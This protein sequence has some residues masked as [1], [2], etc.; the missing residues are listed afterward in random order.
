[1][2]SSH[3]PLALRY[4]QL[5]FSA[6]KNTGDFN[7]AADTIQIM[8]VS[9]G[10]EFPVVALPGVGRMPAAGESEKDA[11]RVFFVAA[12]RATQRLVVAVNGGSFLERNCSSNKQC[13]EIKT[14]NLVSGNHFLP[15]NLTSTIY[16]RK[17]CWR[18]FL[19][20]RELVCYTMQMEN[21]ILFAKRR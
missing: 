12:T 15:L 6:R 4:R 8:K 20:C 7:P 10:L 19:K 9:K 17:Q 16:R 3:A 11:V 1:M 2:S 14:G 5:S 13:N 18:E 21:L